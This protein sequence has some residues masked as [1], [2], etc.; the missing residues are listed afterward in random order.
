MKNNIHYETPFWYY[1]VVCDRCGKPVHNHECERFLPPNEF[2]VDFC[3][4][5]MKYIFNNK[6]PYTEI[7]NEYLERLYLL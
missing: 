4:E 7:A 5:C 1:T 2:E 6:I 3:Q